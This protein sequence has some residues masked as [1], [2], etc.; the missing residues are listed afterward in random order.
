MWAVVRARLD[1]LHLGWAPGCLVAC[2]RIAPGMTKLEPPSRSGICPHCGGEL[3]ALFRCAACGA[4][5]QAR[6]Y[7]I[8][9]VIAQT[10]HSRIYLAEDEACRRVAL[11][12]LIFSLVP[13]IE[14]LTA[15]EREANFLRRLNHAGIPHFVDSF[16]LGEGVHTRLYL[17]QEYIEGE[18]LAVAID[19][20]TLNEPQFVDI[21]RQVLRILVY[22]HGQIPKAIHRDIKPQNLILQP[23]GHVALVDF[24]AARD[25]STSQTHGST[26]VGTFGYMPPEQLGGTVDETSD[27]YGLG[28]SLLHAVTGRRPEL[29]IHGGIAPDFSKA[30][31][32]L[33]SARRRWLLK[34]VEPK[35][36]ARYRSAEIALRDLEDSGRRKGGLAAAAVA[37]LGILALAV[38]SRMSGASSSP[39]DPTRERRETQRLL[40]E[41]LERRAETGRPAAPLSQPRVGEPIPAS[42]AIEQEAFRHLRALFVAERAYFAEHDSYSAEMRFVGFDPDPWCPDGARRSIQVEAAKNEAVGCHFVYSVDLEGTGSTGQFVLRA[43]GAAAPALGL[44]YVVRSDGESRGIPQRVPKSE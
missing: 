44:A 26:L 12:E 28:A 37:V 27:L 25:L 36:S 32:P 15:F 22:I 31:L 43:R 40:V 39:L 30:K 21:A 1:R 17:A 14:A 10:P 8:L 13:S 6:G 23:N 3:A 20:G 29:W 33:S 4:I 34:L 19:R 9:R 38:L 16:Q 42:D 24:G 41:T 5:S 18:S 2:G 11:K 7:R 35:R